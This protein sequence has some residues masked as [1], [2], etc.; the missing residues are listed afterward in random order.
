METIQAIKCILND[1][2]RVLV[3]PIDK[4]SPPSWLPAFAYPSAELY[5]L[6]RPVFDELVKR[7]QQKPCNICPA[8]KQC[9]RVNGVK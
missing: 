6:D 5:W 3:G 2:E 8:T 7:G 1:P 9:A 4:G